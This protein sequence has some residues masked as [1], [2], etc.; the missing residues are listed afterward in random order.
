MPALHAPAVKA[1]SCQRTEELPHAQ[2]GLTNSAVCCNAVHTAALVAPVRHG[3][4][5]TGGNFDNRRM[6]IGATLYLPVE[7]AG[8]LL[9]A[10]DGHAAMGDSELSGTG[11]ETSLDGKLK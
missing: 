8:A 10:G 2:P 3:D 6:G 4:P 5:P 1:P 7:V 11:I 9:F